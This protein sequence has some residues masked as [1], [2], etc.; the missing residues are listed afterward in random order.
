MGE[1]VGTG[2]GENG[3]GGPDDAGLRCPRCGY[4]LTGLPQPRC[5]ECGR[6]FEWEHVRREAQ[7]PPRIAFER[8]R[9]WRRVP[10]F[11]VTWAAVL[12][13]PW[14]FAGQI[15]RRASARHALAFA[16]VCF[17][18]TASALVLTPFVD[19]LAGWLVIAA[20]CV[21]AQ[22]VW[23]TLIDPSGPREPRATFRF[24][25]LAGCYTSAVMVTE[26]TG[27]PI[28]TLGDLW[29]FSCGSLGVSYG[30]T[31]EGLYTASWAALIGWVQIGLWLIGLAFCCRARWRRAGL[32]DVLVWPVIVLV[33]VTV[34]LLNGAVVQ[35]LWT[36]GVRWFPVLS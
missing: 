30:Y 19:M 6:G 14:I 18:S 8:A 4:N 5:P 3:Q 1:H 23:L 22:A 20:T 33:M 36:V 21:L 28:V 16:G 2:Q 13:A 15:V 17:A 31:F 26:V 27:P 11:F 29:I 35:Y 32:N 34:L 10:A 12:F 9:G 7:N 25:L 24:W